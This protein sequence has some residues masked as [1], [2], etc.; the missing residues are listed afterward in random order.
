MESVT[1]PPQMNRFKAYGHLKVTYKRLYRTFK[2][3]YRTLGL[4]PVE[5][6]NFYRI[7]NVVP[8]DKSSFLIL[9]MSQ[10]L[11]DA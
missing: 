7:G 5:K 8:V 2:R 3:L 10:N 6:L 1:L 4:R 9:T 11:T